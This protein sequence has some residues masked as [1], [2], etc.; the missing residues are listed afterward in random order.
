[1]TI[2]GYVVDY[3]SFF[4]V[5]QS[6]MFAY[7]S[8][9]KRQTKLVKDKMESNLIKGDGVKMLQFDGVVLVEDVQSVVGGASTG[10]ASASITSIASKLKKKKFKEEDED[11]E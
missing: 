4:L 8:K 5:P 7:N 2:S 9:S 10:F 1:M 6:S 3:G 11:D